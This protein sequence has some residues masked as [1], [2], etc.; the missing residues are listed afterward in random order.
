MDSKQKLVLPNDVKTLLHTL[1]NAGYEGYVVGGCVRDSFLQ[2]RELNDWDICTNAK[3]DQVLKIFN[4]YNVIETG[5]K[6]GT[7]TVLVNSVGYEITTY[8]IDGEYKDNRRPENVSFVSDLEQ[9]LKRRDFTINALAYNESNGLID[10]NNGIL[11]IENKVIKCV[12]VAHNRFNEDALRIIRGLRFAS[13]LGFNI[14]KD[15]ELAMFDL[16]DNLRNVSNERVSTEFCKLI[17]GK[18]ATEILRKYRD[19]IAVFIPEITE[20]FDFEQNSPYHKYDVWE[21]TIQAVDNIPAN[22]LTLR[23]SAFFHDIG[24]PKTYTQD[25]KGIGHFYKHAFVSQKIAKNVLT[26]LNFSN[27]M[28]NQICMLVQHHDR[29]LIPNKKSILKFLNKFD[30]DFLNDYIVLRTADIKAQGTFLDERLQILVETKQISQTIIAENICYKPSQ[31][32]INGNDL[33]KLGIPQGEKIGQ[34]LTKLM[35]EILNEKLENDKDILIERA[36]IFCKQ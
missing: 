13:V 14:E 29:P 21:H 5:L 16:K 9:D 15:T 31:L 28:I 25:E 23:L 27:D 12:G 36:K 26:R 17:T 3:P 33:I 1:S 35:K 2:S 4:D 24:K 34:I 19:I 20:M 18:N 32:K 7:V 10:Y 30:I 11:D 6:H 8:R 22:M